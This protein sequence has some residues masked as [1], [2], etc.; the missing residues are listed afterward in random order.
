MYYLQ[1]YITTA[2]I[3]KVQIHRRDECIPITKV[4]T[5]QYIIIV[6]TLTITDTC[7][8]YDHIFH[9]VNRSYLINWSNYEKHT[10]T[11]NVMQTSA[12]YIIT[13][14]RFTADYKCMLPMCLST[15]SIVSHQ[16]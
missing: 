6:Q 12:N 11:S 14:V 9:N 13:G 8:Y 5:K 16:S 3:V 10:T 1:C 15:L 2:V 4:H 7:N